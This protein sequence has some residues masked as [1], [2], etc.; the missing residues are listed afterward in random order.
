M[1]TYISKNTSI[2]CFPWRHT[3]ARFKG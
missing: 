3:L 1:E 2:Q